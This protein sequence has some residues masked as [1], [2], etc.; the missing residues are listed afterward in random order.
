MPL[1]WKQVK[2]GLDPGRFTIRTVPALLARRRAWAGYCD[3]ERP[4]PREFRRIRT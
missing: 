4:L 1:D 2:K 3:A